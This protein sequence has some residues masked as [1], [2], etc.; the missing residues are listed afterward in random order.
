MAYAP[1]RSMNGSLNDGMT[2]GTYK[3]LNRDRGGFVET[4]TQDARA[5]LYPTNFGYIESGYKEQPDGTHRMGSGDTHY[6]SPI[7]HQG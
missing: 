4:T 3:K 2:D 6:H 7:R 5:D 1:Q